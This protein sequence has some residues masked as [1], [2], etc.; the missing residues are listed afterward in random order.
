MGSPLRVR[1]GPG[2]VKVGAT[3]ALVVAAL[4]A[5]CAE[6]ANP[7]LLAPKLVIH[8]LEDGNVTL[9][10]HG[11]FQDRLYDRLAL[12]IDNET[13]ESREGSFSLERRVAATGFFAEVAAWTGAQ[14]YRARVRVD[15]DPPEARARVAALD[16]D[17]LWSDPE[18][19]A[20]PYG[21][22]LERVTA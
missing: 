17:G 5:G 9:Y 21:R 13:V 10:V 11:A 22:V 4:S 12:S 14:E 8:A 3:L 15:V 1:A 19:F 20:L 16:G 2:G 6:E 18:T 7:H